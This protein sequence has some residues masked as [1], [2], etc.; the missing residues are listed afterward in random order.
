MASPINPAVN[1]SARISTTITTPQQSQQS[2]F[3]QRIGSGLSTAAGTVGQVAGML[4]NTFGGGGAGGVISA[5]VNGANALA[6]NP[7]AVASSYAASGATGISGVTPSGTASGGSSMPAV[8]NGAS[9]GNVQQN[10]GYLQEFEQMNQRMLQT[11]V[12]MQK[13]SNHFNTV[14]NVLKNRHETQRNTLQNVK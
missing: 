4:G 2:T 12:H 11:Q 9:T 6:M 14:S 5:A 3:G 7:G 13:E 8:G 1:N 10:Q